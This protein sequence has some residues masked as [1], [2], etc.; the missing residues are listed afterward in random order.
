KIMPTISSAD[1]DFQESFL[2]LHNNSNQ[3]VALNKD[4]SATIYIFPVSEF[5]PGRKYFS[6]PYIEQNDE[7]IYEKINIQNSTFLLETDLYKKIPFCIENAKPSTA[8]YFTFDGSS[9]T[10]T[11]A[12]PLHRIGETTWSREIRGNRPPVFVE[13]GDRSI[14]V[15]SSTGSGNSFIIL[16]SAGKE[17][18]SKSGNTGAAGRTRSIASMYPMTGNNHLV[19]GFDHEQRSLYHSILEKRSEDDVLIWSLPAAEYGDR[20]YGSWRCAIQKDENTWLVAGLAADYGDAGDDFYRPYIIKIR[21]HGD[22]A[23]LLWELGPDSFLYDWYRVRSA[24]YNPVSDRYLV[25]GDTPN[26]QLGKDYHGQGSFV[27]FISDSGQLLD[28]LTI[29]NAT[30]NTV[31]C[32]ANGNFYLIGEEMRQGRVYAVIRKFDADGNS[33]KFETKPLSAHS[34][35][36]CAVFDETSGLLVLGGTYGA[37]TVEGS[38]GT[39]FIQGIDA[40]SGEERWIE[41][42]SAVSRN[43]RLVTAL[44]KAVDYG[45]LIS[46]CGV[47]NRN[48]AEPFIIA[49]LN[50]QGRLI[51]HR[52]QN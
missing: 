14:N 8:Y 39:S 2:I 16:D 22:S 1:F 43:V 24:A 38:R 34:Y 21:D 25:I 27:A 4:T 51:E 42:L 31:V 47:E 26:P 35:Y 18:T 3:T 7:K 20:Q 33:L 11:D 17:I 23:E 29:N 52:I 30:F 12:R 19:I 49:R 41:N 6:S 36:E 46:L 13:N 48:Y 44:Q 5:Y 50:S 37:E 10:L 32:D 28:S 9:V 45:Y 40:A 15:V